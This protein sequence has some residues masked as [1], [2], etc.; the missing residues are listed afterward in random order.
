MK[1]VYLISNNLSH[2]LKVIKTNIL[3]KLMSN[4]EKLLF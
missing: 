1:T 3:H 4:R 2:S